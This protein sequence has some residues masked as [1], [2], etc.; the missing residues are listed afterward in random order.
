MTGGITYQ[1]VLIIA[2]AVRFP[3]V[4]F[5]HTMRGISAKCK[6]Y[7]KHNE[8]KLQNRQRIKHYF[9]RGRDTFFLV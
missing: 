3:L 1:L 5:G 8:G 9:F 4:M 7:V 6:Q 2:V